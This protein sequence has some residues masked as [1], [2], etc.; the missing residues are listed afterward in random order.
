MGELT[1]HLRVSTR[2]G[3]VQISYAADLKKML[4]HIPTPET[5]DRFET[6]TRVGR[7]LADLHMNYEKVEPYPVKVEKGRVIVG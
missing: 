6:V 2:A 3:T 4:P 7:M 5:R 1:A